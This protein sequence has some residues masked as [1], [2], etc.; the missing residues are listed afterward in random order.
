M[1]KRFEG[2]KYV[3]RLKPEEALIVR[4]MSKNNTLL[5]NILSTIR[6]KSST[7]STTIKHIYNACHRLRKVGGPGGKNEDATTFEVFD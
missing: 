2:H 3:E 1:T 6:N 7:S 4:E 5:R